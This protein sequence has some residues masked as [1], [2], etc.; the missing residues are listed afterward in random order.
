MMPSQR[1][2]IIWTNA[3][4][5]LIQALGTNFGEILGNACIFIKENTFKNVVREMAAILSRPQYVKC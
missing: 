4:I 3:A 2:A 1:Q 5:L